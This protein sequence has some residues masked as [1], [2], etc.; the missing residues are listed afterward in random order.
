MTWRKTDKLLLAGGVA[1][2]KALIPSV[3]RLSEGTKRR[4]LLYKQRW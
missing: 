3:M 1:E 4:L 2:E